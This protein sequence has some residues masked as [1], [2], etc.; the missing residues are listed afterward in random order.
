MQNKKALRER[1]LSSSAAKLDAV[2]LIVEEN[3]NFASVRYTLPQIVCN[4]DSLVKVTNRV[5]GNFYAMSERVLNGLLCEAMTSTASSH[6][7]FD[8]METFVSGGPIGLSAL[9]KADTLTSEYSENDIKTL[10]K[11]AK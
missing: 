2:K 8:D 9:D 10:H 5:N 6:S 7:F 4:A 11:F 3:V 1:H